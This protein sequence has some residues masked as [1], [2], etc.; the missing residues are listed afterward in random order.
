MSNLGIS[1]FIN[2]AYDVYE[3]RQNTWKKTPSPEGRWTCSGKSLAHYDMDPLR[4]LYQWWTGAPQ[5]HFVGQ[6]IDNTCLSDY[7][8]FFGTAKLSSIDIYLEKRGD[9]V[10]E[11]RGAFSLIIGGQTCSANYFYNKNNN[12]EQMETNCPSTNGLP[13]NT[14]EMSVLILHMLRSPGAPPAQK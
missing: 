4:A 3:D 10:L 8:P 14:Q 12:T 5:D 6:I 11:A 9:Q 13:F 2:R 7:A 1:S